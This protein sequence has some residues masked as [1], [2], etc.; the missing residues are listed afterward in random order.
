MSSRRPPER[1]PRA[2]RI[3]PVLRNEHLQYAITWY[4]RRRGAHDLVRLLAQERPPRGV[5]PAL[6]DLLAG[7]RRAGV[8]RYGASDVT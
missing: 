3:V 5:A 4:W 7:V 8:I 2:G 6:T 1:P